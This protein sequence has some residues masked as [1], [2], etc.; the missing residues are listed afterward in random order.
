M[1]WSLWFYHLMIYKFCA[2]PFVLF[3]VL[4]AIPSENQ[5]STSVSF[6]GPSIFFQTVC[7]QHTPS[8]S[9]HC[10]LYIV[11]PWP[12]RIMVQCSPIFK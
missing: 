9:S 5:I 3:Y 2:D 10:L 8:N 12:P 6:T 1:S 11:L 7:P 4:A